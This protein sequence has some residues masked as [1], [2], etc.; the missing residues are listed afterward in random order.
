MT[1]AFVV[2][3]VVLIGVVWLV[4]IAAF[5]RDLIVNWNPPAPRVQRRVMEHRRVNERRRSA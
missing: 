4:V 1:A 3:C 5:V 2:F